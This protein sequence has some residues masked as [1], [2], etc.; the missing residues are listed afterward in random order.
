MKGFGSKIIELRKIKGYTQKQLAEFLQISPTRLNYWEKDKREPDL[1][2]I[3]K[4]CEVLDI[5]PDE[6]LNIEKNIILNELEQKIILEYRT[7]I[8][9][10]NIVNVWLGVENEK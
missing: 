7:N 8:K 4:L 9:F 6:L 5:S 2:N 10:K 1:F 3:L